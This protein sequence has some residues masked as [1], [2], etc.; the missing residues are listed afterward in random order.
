MKKLMTGVLVLAAMAGTAMAQEGG[1]KV[2]QPD[3]PATETKTDKPA[4]QKFPGPRGTEFTFPTGLYDD[5]AIPAD[6]IAQ[7]I[8]KAKVD[9]KRV[10]AMFGENYCGFCVFL[11]D[12]LKN[13]P[14]VAPVLKT[15]YEWIKIDLG[16]KFTKNRNVAE[17]YG[18]TLWTPRPDGSSLGAPALCVIDPN[19]G[20][21]VAVLG[22]N[23]MVAKPMTMTRVFDESK[24]YQFLMDNRAPG[25]AADSV[26]GEA[27]SEAGKSGKKILAVFSMPL[28]DACDAVSAWQGRGDVSATLGNAF[29]TTKIDSERMTG[30]ADLLKKT[31]GK[32]LLPPYIAVLN[33]DGSV[34][35]N[36]TFTALPKTDAEIEGFLKALAANSKMSEADKA[37]L[38]KS[39]REAAMAKP[40]PKK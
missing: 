5:N 34:V 10:L 25:K 22:G 15:E 23:D 32:A 37:V 38:T 24:I 18:V 20:R 26:L 29:V 31:A 39:L 4:E 12:I 40:E 1:S 9:N 27:K 14:N 13:D 30:G 6:Q 21:H 19:T 28:N 3:A 36:A 8:A 35:E 33:A 16:Q 2:F 17:Q 7:A 11:N